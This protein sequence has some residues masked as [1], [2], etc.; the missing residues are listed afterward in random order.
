M[1]NAN[2]FYFIII[3]TLFVSAPDSCNLLPCKILS[4]FLLILPLS[5]WFHVKRRFNR[6][7]R[8]LT[9]GKLN[10]Q[11]AKNLCRSMISFYSAIAVVIFIC[12][13]FLFDLKIF[14]KAVPVIGEWGT[15]LNILGVS[16]LSYIYQSYGCG[17]TVPLAAH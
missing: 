2:F 11:D 15:G 8:L 16:F 14:L 3:I 10:I 5:F 4:G 13:I 12:A 7:K 6:V 9:D 17:H 1:I